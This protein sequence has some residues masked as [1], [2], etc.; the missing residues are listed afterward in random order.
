MKIYEKVRAYIDAKG[1]KHNV[2]AHNAQ[3]SSKTFS[4]IMC[5]RRV[6]YAD[7]LE[8]ICNALGVSATLFIRDDTRTA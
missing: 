4:A 8:A 6:M 2:V 5:G 1:L 3:I 7:D